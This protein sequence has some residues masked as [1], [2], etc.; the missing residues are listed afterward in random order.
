[1]QTLWYI[2]DP[3]CS[4]C[5]GFSPIIET[6]R[7]I[8]KNQLQ[9][10]LIVG[11]LRAGTT[12]PLHPSKRSEILQHWQNVQHRTSQPFKFENALPEDF[13]YDTEPACR[14]LVTA[15]TIDSDRVFALLHAIQNAFYAEQLDVTRTEILS[16]L[17]ANV[18]IQPE[19]FIATYNS[20][21]LKLKTQQQFQ[22][23][24]QWGVS[25]F[26]S[27]VYLKNNAPNFLM[28]GYCDLHELQTRITTVL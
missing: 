17:A 20:D 10:E 7:E 25:G 9:I 13:I 2:A 12:E 28:R 16:Q 5:W 8:Y 14:A 23:A 24:V 11:G 1:M 22:Q 6:I 19:R 15:A 21:T 4:W 26:P 27:L 3:M 18:G